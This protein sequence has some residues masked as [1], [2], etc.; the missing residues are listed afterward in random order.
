MPYDEADETDPMML[1]GVELPADASSWRETAL[2]LA[3][4]FARMGFCEER[5]MEV[6]RDPFYAGA[7]QAFLALGEEE[8]REIVRAAATPW[9]GIAFRERDADPETGLDLLPV[10][11]PPRR[12]DT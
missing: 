6:F 8:V 7:H 5:L 10:L 12:N 3:E 11:D 1:V 9:K 4:E 2:V